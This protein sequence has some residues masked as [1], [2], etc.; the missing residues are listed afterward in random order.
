MNCSE[1]KQV[2][3]EMAEGSL[4]GRDE[5]AALQHLAACEECRAEFGRL[6]AAV[7]AVRRAVPELAPQERYLT[8]ERLDRLMAAHA[9]SGKLFKLVTYRQ[10]IGGAAA[11]CIVIS[12]AF[13]AAHLIGMHEG[14]TAVPSPQ[15]AAAPSPYVPVVLAAQRYGEPMTVVHG[16]SGAPDGR[17]VWAEPAPNESLVETDTSGVFVPVNHAFYDAEESSHWW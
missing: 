2:L 15:Q 7:G 8:S 1:A 4:A 6:R 13:I 16:T 11:A 5:T 10:F 14:A 9:R 17:Q 12:G 3:V